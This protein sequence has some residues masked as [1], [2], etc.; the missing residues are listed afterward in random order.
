MVQVT[1][2]E[3]PPRRG[4]RTLAGLAAPLL[5][6]AGTGPA[7]AHVK[8][9]CAYDV[10]GQPQ[11]LE[12]VL[13]PDFEWLTGLALVCLMAGCLARAGPSC[14]GGPCITPAVDRPSESAS[15]RRVNPTKP[16][17]PKPKTL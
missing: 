14:R 13:C 5:L 12:Q 3:R 11:G 7:S 9:F 8:W 10:A 6:L 17:Q 15:Q 1:A 2:L 16:T 4:R